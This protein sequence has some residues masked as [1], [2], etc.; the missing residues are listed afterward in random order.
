M[1]RVGTTLMG[2]LLIALG[3]CG[4]PAEQ[5]PQKSN[6][7]DNLVGTWFAYRDNVIENMWTFRKDGTCINDGWPSARVLSGAPALPYHLEGAYRVGDDR[8]TVTFALESGEHD[9]V[10]LYEPDI[11]RNRLVYSV[12]DAPVVYL[13][14]RTAVGHEMAAAADSGAIDPDL[15][16][17][18]VGSWVALTDGFPVNTWKFNADGT[19][20]NEGWSRMNPRMLLVRRLYQVT[21]RYDVSGQR[22]V[23]ANERV[24]QFDP[25][26][27]KV[28]VEVPIS[29]RIVLYNVVISKGRLV[30]TNEVGLPV[31]FRPGVVSPTHW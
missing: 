6:L 5:P 11:T 10:V 3:A 25:E 24:L 20:E 22:V 26:T 21:G 9:T 16:H 14:E 19:F 27:N 13:R 17:K 31:A 29:E 23:L 30:Y 1:S 2:V 8:I 18:L 12:G 4:K 7:S 28:D 15:P